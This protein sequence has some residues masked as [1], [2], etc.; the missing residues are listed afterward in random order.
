MDETIRT[1]NGTNQVSY[2][3]F[4][5]LFAKTPL[6][7]FKEIIQRNKLLQTHALY[8]LKIASYYSSM[9]DSN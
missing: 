5:L 3:Y 1:M 6:K 8:R 2:W 7:G 9:T 4:S